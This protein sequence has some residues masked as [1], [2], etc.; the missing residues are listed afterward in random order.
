L[1]VSLVL[2]LVIN[3]LQQWGRRYATD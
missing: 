3:L 2:L 1:M